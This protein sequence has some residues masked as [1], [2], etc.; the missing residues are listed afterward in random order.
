MFCSILS[1][2][3]KFCKKNEQKR[4]KLIALHV[5]KMRKSSQKNICAK[6]TKIVYQIYGHF[7]ETLTGSS[8]V[9]V[10]SGAYTGFSPPQKIF[11]K[12]CGGGGDP[13]YSP[14]LTRTCED[15]SGRQLKNKYIKS[16]IIY[17]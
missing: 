12:K 8:L 16:K 3:R 14:D 17:F 6:I 7:L 4:A 15:P 10:K 5:Q 9:N 2:L 11:L 13:F 1:V